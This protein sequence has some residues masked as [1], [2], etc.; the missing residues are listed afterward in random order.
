[1]GRKLGRQEPVAPIQISRISRTDKP[2]EGVTESRTIPNLS[3]V[4]ISRSVLPATFTG[5]NTRV[6]NASDRTQLLKN[7]TNLGKLEKADIIKPKSEKPSQN[8]ST[9]SSDKGVDVVQL[10]VDSLPNELT[11]PPRKKVRQLLQENEAIFS[12]GEYDIGRTQVVEY[13][14][15]TGTHRPIRQPLRRHQFKYLEVIDK[16]VE[17]MT[18][19]GIVEPAASPWA[20]NVV[21]VRKK[22]SS[23]RFCIGRRQLNRITT[24][25]N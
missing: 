11:E 23:L 2:F 7:G 24:Q 13:R 3:H 1:M 17:E 16:Q 10:M 19:H 5:L 18:K 22:N 14:I 21:L 15:D 20:S 12:K 6:V 4:Y 8:K 9:D 25:D